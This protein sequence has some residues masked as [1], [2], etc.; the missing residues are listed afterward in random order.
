MNVLKTSCFAILTLISVFSYAQTTEQDITKMVNAKR[1]IFVAT[2]ATPMN[3]MDISKVMSKMQGGLQGGFIDLHGDNYDLV[4][5]PDSVV[6]FL[7]YYG[8]AYTA[9][10]NQTD[11]GIKFTSK[12]F[13]YTTTKRKKGSWDVE[14]D[15]KDANEGYRLSL[16]IGKTGNTTLSVRSN[17]RQSVTFNG[18]LKEMKKP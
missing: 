3:V 15:V 14:I 16:N 4:I 18:Y 13:A 10:I 9:P 2:S 1:Y 8:R 11:G 12:K 7:P 5:T 17:N 6:A